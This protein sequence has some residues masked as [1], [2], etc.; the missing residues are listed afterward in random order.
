MLSGVSVYEILTEYPDVLSVFIPEIVP[1]IGFDQKSPYHC[2]DVWTHT[3]ASV[4]A[5]PAHF[6]HEDGTIP[7]APIRLTMLFHDIGKPSCF[8]LD[9][10]GVGH[11][12]GHEETGAKIAQRRLKA[13]RYSRGTIEHVCELI[14]YHDVRLNENNIIKWLHKTGEKKMHELLVVMAADAKAHS[15]ATGE[16]TLRRLSAALSAL[17]KTISEKRCFSLRELAVSGRDLICLGMAEGPGIGTVLDRLLCEVMDEK[18][19][20]ER[21]ALLD[22]APRLAQP[23]LASSFPYRKRYPGLE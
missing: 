17:E 5:A 19:P 13:L 14:R 15:K 21:A 10:Q 9:K 3:A 12:P 20:N 11:F 1:M 7:S 2:F 16:E 23:F 6:V 22:A 18:L 4:A 8:T